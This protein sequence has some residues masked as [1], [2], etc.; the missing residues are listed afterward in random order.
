MKFKFCGD[1]D[2]PDWL[3]AE[4]SNLSKISSVKLK[5]ICNQAVKLLTNDDTF[6]SEKVEKHLSDSKLNS[7]D[8]IKGILAA[9]LFLL[10]GAIANQVQNEEFVSEMQQLGLPK[11]HSVVLG[12]AQQSSV[13]P[14]LKSLRENSLRMN[15]VVKC[16]AKPNFYLVETSE[17]NEWGNKA[18]QCDSVLVEISTSNCTNSKDEKVSFNVEKERLNLLIYELKLAQNIANRFSE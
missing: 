8:D 13:D 4:I 14:I 2:C 9:I 17:S 18:I 1:L 15:K 16:D 12:K 3:L 7:E 6:D 5:L 10:K 11:E